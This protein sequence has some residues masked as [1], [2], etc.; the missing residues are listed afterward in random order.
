MLTE[1]AEPVSINNK[2]VQMPMK[3]H[4]GPSSS[5]INRWMQPIADPCMCDFSRNDPNPNHWILAKRYLQIAV[6]AQAPAQTCLAAQL[7]W[8]PLCSSCVNWLISAMQFKI[9]TCMCLHLTL[10]TAS[11]LYWLLYCPVYAEATFKDSAFS[12]GYVH[13][14]HAGSFEPAWSKPTGKNLQ[15]LCCWQQLAMTDANV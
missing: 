10:S 13:H 1:A 8:V 5:I 15:V 11:W 3:P 12:V 6:S 14:K 9:C 7:R 4:M 2:K